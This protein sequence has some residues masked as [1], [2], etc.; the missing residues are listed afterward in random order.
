ME[1]IKRHFNAVVFALFNITEN[2]MYEI[3]GRVN[4]FT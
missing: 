2:V 3:V 1:A 4:L